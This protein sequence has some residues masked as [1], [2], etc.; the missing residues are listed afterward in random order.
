MVKV[1]AISL[2]VGVIG[3]LVVILGGALA[4]NLGRRESD[5]GRMIGRT[6]RAV[7]G[8]LV[9]FGMAGMSAEFSSLDFGWQIALLL[10]IVGAV[11]GALWAWFASKGEAGSDAGPV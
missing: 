11:A 5:P 3:L 4:E 10:A 2:T 1:Y 9:G 7:I 8:G 6:G